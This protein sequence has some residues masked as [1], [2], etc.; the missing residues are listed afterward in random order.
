MKNKILHITAFSGALA[1][2][3]LSGC[4]KMLDQRPVTQVVTSKPSDSTITASAAESAI[5]GVYGAFKGAGY[6]PGIEFNV[7]DRITN[8]DVLSDN[9]YSGGDNPD[10]MAIDLFT[11]NALNGNIA[12]DWSDCY[13]VIGVANTA[14]AQ[15]GACND[16]ALTVARKNQILGEARFMRAFQ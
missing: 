10:N 9:C 5:Q 2:L 11:F 6:G 3:V 15:I 13:S 16:P 8:G 14:I 7:L 4:T 12:R 1:V